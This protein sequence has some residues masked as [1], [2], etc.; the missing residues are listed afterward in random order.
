MTVLEN[1][2]PALS[3]DRTAIAA[4]AAGRYF[5]GLDVD[6]FALRLEKV[7]AAMRE[8]GL[9]DI[10]VYSTLMSSTGVSYLSNYEVSVEAGAMVHVSATGDSALYVPSEQEAEA[11]GTTSWMSDIRVAPDLAAAAAA[12]LAERPQTGLVGFSIVPRPMWSRLR[13]GLKAEPLHAGSLL[14]EVAR[15]KTPREIEVIRRAAAIA[16]VGFLAARDAFRPGMAE[17]ELAAEYEHAMRALGATDNFG[18]LSIGQDNTSIGF[19]TEYRA[20]PGDIA[21]F[22]ITPAIESRSYSA[23]L[24]RSLALVPVRPKVEELFPLLQQALEA[25]I[26]ECRPGVKASTVVNAQDEVFRSAGYAEYCRPPY[27]RARG[28]GFGLGRIDLSADNDELLEVGVAMVVHPN[29][30]LPEAGYLALGEMVV[31]TEDGCERLS[32]LGTELTI[33]R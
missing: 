31:I 2:V 5:T 10:L 26:A 28:H 29:Q 24:C 1:S 20:E 22:E 19:V 15:V 32:S 21:L 9:D 4:K 12:V 18:L 11:A 6:E 3:V 33:V 30:F 14:E 23:Q 25:G 13:E 7:T 17:F 16:D 27:M 8:R